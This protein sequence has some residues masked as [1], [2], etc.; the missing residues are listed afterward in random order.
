MAKMV[1]GWKNHLGSSR[2]PTFVAKSQ[3]PTGGVAMTLTP[4][5]RP[6]GFSP[7]NQMVSPGQHLQ[8]DLTS[9]APGGSQASTPTLSGSRG[10]LYFKNLSQTSST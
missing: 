10:C 3:P 6:L 9:W 5:E 1:S 4:A 8:S 2:Q 7:G